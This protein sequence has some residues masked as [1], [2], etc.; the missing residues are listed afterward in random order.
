MTHVALEVV[1]LAQ[2]RQ[3]RRCRPF[4]VAKRI[5]DA[6]PDRSRLSRV[7]ARER[8]PSAG[9]AAAAAGPCA[10]IARAAASRTNGLGSFS[11]ASRLPAAPARPPWPVRQRERGL[12]PHLRVRIGP[13][14]LDDAGHVA[15]SR[16]LTSFAS[17]QPSAPARA[18]M[19]LSTPSVKPDNAGFLPVQTNVGRGAQYLLELPPSELAVEPDV[20]VRRP[21]CRRFCWR[22]SAP[23]SC[24]AALR[25]RRLTVDEDLVLPVV[26]RL[27]DLRR[28]RRGRLVHDERHLDAGARPLRL[29][30]ENV[31]FPKSSFETETFPFSARHAAGDA[32]ASSCSRCRAAGGPNRTAPAA[33]RPRCPS[34]TSRRPRTSGP[35]ARRTPSSPG[36]PGCRP[37]PCARSSGPAAIS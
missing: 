6:A 27:R 22:M 25:S 3:S 13:Q 9:T 23:G 2:L 8:V 18:R 36:R 19:T 10:P 17:A 35:G 21:S 33:A 24:S 15:A 26:R 30:E 28:A 5:E 16:F 34:G 20:G 37:S 12:R 31:L 14:R 29:E 4:H 11:A 7:L 32:S 1:E